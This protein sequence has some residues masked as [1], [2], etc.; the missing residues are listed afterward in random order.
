[1][2]PWTER[3]IKLGKKKGYITYGQ[4]NRILPDSECTPNRLYALLAALE[5]E[6]IDL[7]T[8]RNEA[9]IPNS[10]LRPKLT[11]E[12][13]ELANWVSK[14]S[15]RVSK[16]NKK[17]IPPGGSAFGCQNKEWLELKRQMRKGDQLRAYGIPPRFSGPLYGQWGVALVRKGKVIA[18]ITTGVS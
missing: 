7:V 15:R 4:V 2:T 3:C 10:W 11:I 17:L 9:L 8:R 6:K 18:E 5:R 16:K 12:E 1:M 13:A 14:D